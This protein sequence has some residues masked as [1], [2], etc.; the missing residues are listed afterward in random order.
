[1]DIALG[2]EIIKSLADESRLR[3]IHSLNEKA[4]Y[5]EELANRLNLAGSTV[6]FH[7]K[8]LEAVGLVEKMKEQYYVV[9]HLK[10][11]IFN[12]TL[13][14]L[15][16]FPNLEEVVQTERIESYRVKV[17]KTFMRENKLLS[18]PVQ[19][20]KRLIILDEFLRMFE[21]GKTY[22]EKEVDKIINTSFDDHCTIR[23]LLVEEGMMARENQ[24]YRRIENNERK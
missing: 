13:R 14:D 15:I 16:S 2:M 12:L 20:K 1:M 6:S 11:E 4:Q 17:I 10:A 5:V 18:L 7:L 9:Y 23:R 3:I 19:N 24:L 21:V 22:P 8:K